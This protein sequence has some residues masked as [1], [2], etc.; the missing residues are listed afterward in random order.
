MA[1]KHWQVPVVYE[2]YGTVNVE[3]ETAEEAYR[4]VKDHPEEFDLP[5]N[6]R[7]VDESLKVADEH[8]RNAVPVINMLN[9]T[10]SYLKTRD[11]EILKIAQ[12]ESDITGVSYL[13][14]LDPPKPGRY[15]VIRYQNVIKTF[16]SRKELGWNMKIVKTDKWYDPEGLGIQPPGKVFFEGTT[17]ECFAKI[18]E[19]QKLHNPNDRIFVEV[20]RFRTDPQGIERPDK[21]EVYYMN[22]IA[23]EIY[24]MEEDS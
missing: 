22:A 6:G 23:K 2:T 18:A 21:I 19:L 7:Y 12:I 5:E 3:A 10:P 14:E 11:G 20:L 4:F 8:E 9:D 16:H 24:A 1:R 13:C 17:E 15:R